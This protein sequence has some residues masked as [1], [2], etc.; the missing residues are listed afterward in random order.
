M[1]FIPSRERPHKLK[2]FLEAARKTGMSTSLM[3]VVDETEPKIA[4]YRALDCDIMVRPGESIGAGEKLNDAVKLYPDLK[5]YGFLPDDCEPM[6]QGW[7]VSLSEA[8]QPDC[9]AYSGRGEGKQKFGVLAIGGDLLRAVGFVAPPGLQHYGGDRF[10]N[11]LSTRAGRRRI[12]E[13]CIVRLT[14]HAHEHDN[15]PAW[16]EPKRRQKARQ[17]EDKAAWRALQDAGFVDEMVR[18]LVA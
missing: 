1:W 16:D 17:A 2:R 14:D 8:C 10:W 11:S 13:G 9:V 18:K 6:T 4:D 12:I 15:P 3:V 5:W 7:D